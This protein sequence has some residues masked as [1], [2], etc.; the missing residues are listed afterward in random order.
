[1]LR[2][3]ELADADPSSAER[4]LTFVFAGAGFAGVEAVAEL[5]EL[6]EGALRRHPRL[7]GI[8]PRWVLVDTAPRIL[9]QVPDSLSRFAARTLGRRGVE[10]VSETALASIDRSGAVLSDG[11]RI[12]T[13]TVVW[14]AGVAANPVAARLGLPLDARGRVPVDELFRV[15]GLSD[16]YALGDIAAVPNLA[17]PGEYDPPTCQHA[18]RQAKR[19]GRN[20]S[21]REKPYRFKSLGSM[22]T[23][24]RR[25]GIAVVGSLR[26]RGVLGWGVARGYHLMALPFVARRARVLADWTHAALFRRDVAEL[27]GAA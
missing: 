7:D 26:L 15:N 9:G 23:L 6:A 20:L 1:V 12:E 24:G 22:A 14:T 25:H 8:R 19:L 17:T 11:R 2:R 5:Q 3:I 16:V 27:T 4:R 18:L 13:E 21:G 10:I